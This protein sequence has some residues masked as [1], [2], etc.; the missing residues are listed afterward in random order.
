[1]AKKYAVIVEGEKIEAVEVDGTRY[2]RVEEIRDPTDRERM[3]L[4]LFAWPD[5]DQPARPDPLRRVMIPLFTGLA[6]LMLLIFVISTVSV[7][8]AAAR[9]VSAPGRVVELTTRRSS[10]GQIFSYPLV[11]FRLPDG[12]LTTVQVGEGNWP[13][14]YDRGEEITVRYDR[15][16]PRSARIQSTGSDIGQWTLPIIMGVLTL[17]FTAGAFFVR[18][19]FK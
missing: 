5:A 1:M 4:L 14:A 19:M 7:G 8:R 18:W 13:P 3:E 2:K 12:T 6:A 16:Q 10:D 11:E 15:E 9:E 17:A